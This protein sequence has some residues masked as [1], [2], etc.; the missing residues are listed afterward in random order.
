MSRTKLTLAIAIALFAPVLGSNAASAE[1]EF[2]QCPLGKIK[3]D[4][5]STLPTGWESTAV[6][7][8]IQS[9]IVIRIEGRGQVLQ[10]NYG[11]G[12]GQHGSSRP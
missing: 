8:R 11:R 10:C 5:T 4:V 1:A 3:T 9:V 7:K 2:I 6:E 12:E